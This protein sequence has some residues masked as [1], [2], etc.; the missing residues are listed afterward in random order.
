M[1]NVGLALADVT[2]F[3]P[4]PDLPAF[5]RF[6]SGAFGFFACGFATDLPAF[7][8]A[9]YLAMTDCA[10]YFAAGVVTGGFGA[11]GFGFPFTLNFFAACAAVVAVVSALGSGADGPGSGAGGA[12]ND[13]DGAGTEP[14]GLSSGAEGVSSG[15]GGAG[16][17]AGGADSGAG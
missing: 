1:D 6:T 3:A 7:D 5:G 15:A 2:V 13:A 4:F 10:A 17:G 8:W 16:S 11:F 12:G 9:I 14:G